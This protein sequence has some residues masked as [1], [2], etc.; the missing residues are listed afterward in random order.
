MLCAQSLSPADYEGT[1][2]KLIR[3]KNGDSQ[4]REEL[5]QENLPLV[6][7]VLR[8]FRDRGAEYEDLYQY[9]CIGLVKAVDRFDPSF[10]VRFSTYAVPV[11]MGEVRRYLRDSG[12]VHI[13]R[14]IQENASRVEKFRRTYLQENGSEASLDTI[15][16]ETGLSREEVI[17]AVNAAQRVRS[18]NET[19]NPEGST[20]LMDILGEDSMQA[21]DR[22]ILLAEMLRELNQE[23][24]TII[25]RRYFR[26]STQSEIAKDLGVSQVQVSRMESRILKRLRARA[27]KA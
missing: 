5:V 23:E 13:S 11:I 22:R 10:D 3:A 27:T 24:R 2:E 9:G 19:V 4:A 17:L 20:R 21:V 14:T 25:I 7:Y 16:A 6:H 12:S 1:R 26:S 18:L 15:A 8:R